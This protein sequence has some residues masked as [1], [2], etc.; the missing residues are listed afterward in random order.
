[1]REGRKEMREGRKEMREGRKEMREGH[2]ENAI[3]LVV[4]FMANRKAT[5]TSLAN[6]TL[7]L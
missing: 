4:L 6:H 5:L 7:F 2:K 1:M 3:R